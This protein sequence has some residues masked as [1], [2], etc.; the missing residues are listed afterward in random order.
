M[1]TP[2]EENDADA[3]LVK[4]MQLVASGAYGEAEKICV[5]LVENQPNNAG[6]L[7]A[8]GLTHYMCRRYDQ[9]IEHMTKAIQFDDS[10]PQYYCNLGES[11]RRAMKPDQAL[12]M[13]EKSVALKPEYLLAHLGIANVFR[14]Q[15]RRPEAISRY[16]LALALNPKFA[17]AYHYLG[18]I[19]LEQGRQTEAIAYLR[20]AAALKPDYTEARLALA[21]AL[22]SEGLIDEA[23][24]TYQAI[25]ADTPRVGAAH[26]NVANMLKTKGN[27]DE[28]IVHYEK[29]LELN[30]A[31]VQAHYNLSRARK[32]GES[33]KDIEKM[34]AMLGN[35][36]LPDPD[37]TNIHF[38]LGKVYDDLER[39]D[40]AF[41][42]FAKGNALDNRAP[43]FN[44]AMH[45]Q[46]VNRLIEIFNPNFFAR[47]EGFGSESRRPIFI[48]GMPRSGTTLM[49]QVIASHS[50]VFG[51]GELEQIGQLT[52]AISAEISGAS[53]YPD[54]ANDLDAITACRLG[55]S[56]IT[57][58]KRLSDNSPFVTDKMPGNFMHIGFIS[59][60]LPNARIIHCRRQPMDSCLSCYFQHFT[61][62]MP[63]SV[64]LES[65][66]AYYQAY[67]RLM[68]H[69]VKVLPDK[70]LEIDYEDMVADHEGTT[71]R[72]LEYCGL[73]WEEACIGS[74]E[75]KRT[76][77]TASTW[78]VRQPLYNTSVER[79]K[80]FEKHLQPL[81]DAL[82]PS[83]R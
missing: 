25:I 21:H 72:V 9:A 79:W 60:F 71:R 1:D 24:E 19:F 55:E 53:G 8:L 68:A 49:E 13:F 82:G 47:R 51:A 81:K 7:H 45:N 54:F 74:H 65:L 36:S 20:K 41:E 6:A 35:K 48:V 34:V 10:N 52:N 66:G 73:E 2:Q 69:W 23:I 77:K 67:D 76:V 26:N 5:S 4:A 27:I 43:P 62:P 78:Q 83:F 63:F 30:P 15:Q 80:H 56:Y 31:N 64:S 37:R 14:D 29:A 32:T 46:V 3:G 28:A 75:T 18:V 17:E 22:D 12:S 58:V 70:I 11:Y 38:T 44:N 59:L 33:Q 16:R 42:H 50:M 61:S 40:E 39:Y 57:Y